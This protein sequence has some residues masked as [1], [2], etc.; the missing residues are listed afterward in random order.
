MV[1]CFPISIYRLR[2][3]I[4]MLLLSTI[5]IHTVVFNFTSLEIP[6]RIQHVLHRDFIRELG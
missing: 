2:F 5:E 1:A 3:L 4:F 6:V